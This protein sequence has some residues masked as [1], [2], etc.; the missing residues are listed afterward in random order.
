MS[1]LNDI[2]VYMFDNFVHKK[3][4]T[5]YISTFIVIYSCNPFLDPKCVEIKNGCF[6]AAPSCE[7]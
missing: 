4:F 2:H 5:V 7:R 1:A 6:L 3:E